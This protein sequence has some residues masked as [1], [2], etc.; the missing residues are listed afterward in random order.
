[1]TAGVG[2]CGAAAGDRLGSI[3]ILVV[4]AGSPPGGPLE[5][6]TEVQ[7]MPSLNPA[8]AWARA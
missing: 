8:L 1:M 7:W 4:C 6:L 3:D 5:D 2:R